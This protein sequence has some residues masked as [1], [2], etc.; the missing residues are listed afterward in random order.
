MRYAEWVRK[1]GAQVMLTPQMPL[2]SL[3]LAG[4]GWTPSDW[5]TAFY[6]DDLP[7][8]W[9]VSYYANEFDG[10][11]LPAGGWGQAL[12]QARFWSEEVNKDFCFYLEIT[13]DLLRV[14]HWCDVSLAIDE[15]LSEKVGGLLV[16]GDALPDL[17]A[18]WLGK[19]PLHILQSGQWL[20]DAPE[21]SE[22]QLGVLT[23]T[24]PLDP[25]VLRNV[26][27]QLQ[28]AHTCADVLL[29]VDVPWASV[30]QFRLMQQLYGIYG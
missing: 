20:A 22:L 4:Y 5:L 30:E 6:P 28:Q 10:V 13:Q 9:Q 11:V 17:P 24:Q 2:S 27:E 12:L 26:F 19:Y 18:S 21:G 1:P 23:A 3:T 7:L 25:L 8:D 14:N 16:H 29:F 15:V